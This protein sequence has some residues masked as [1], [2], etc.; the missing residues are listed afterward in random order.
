MSERIR[1]FVG[2]FGSGKSEVAINEALATSSRDLRPTLVDL[3]VVKPYF[4]CRL[5]RDTLADRGVQLELPP[6]VRGMNGSSMVDRPTGRAASTETLIEALAS[7]ARTWPARTEATA[8][9]TTAGG[10][11]RQCS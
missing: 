6:G 5:L 3:D 1:I 2:H 9:R 10:H 8:R 7:A 11:T 4:R